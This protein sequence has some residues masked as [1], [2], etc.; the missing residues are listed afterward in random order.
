MAG[1]KDYYETLG[2]SRDASADE[3]KKAYRK[4]ARKYHP[5][6]NQDDKEAEN[7]FKEV[8]EAFEILSDPQKKQQYDQFGS[9]AFQQGGGSGFGGFG[10]GAGFN[11]EDI[12]SNF[13][14]IFG[15]IFGGGMGRGRGRSQPQSG[16]DLRYD[17]EITLEDA[18]NG[19]EVEVEIPR[20]ETC[21]TCSGSGAK[22][23]TDAKTCPKCGGTGEVKH[24]RR[25]MLGQMVQIGVC[26][27]CNG[28]GK[29]IEDPCEDCSGEGRIRN[30][31][32]IDIKVPKGIDDG[33][34]LRVAGEGDKGQ[35]G[36]PAGDLYIVV[37]VKPHDIFERHGSELY[38]KRTISMSQAAL[39]D[40]I[41]IPTISGKNAELKIPSGTQSHTVFRL[42]GQ[43]MP[44]LRRDS[45]GDMLVKAVVKTPTKLSK[46][47]K[48]ALR[49]LAEEA[50]EEVH[51]TS[52][53]FFDKMK[54][55]W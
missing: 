7:R 55:F 23:G 15:D 48:D 10:G 32:K 14:D 39:G 2:V 41:K 50:G 11:A 36:A 29:I 54:E 16:A 17:L 46:K 49:I 42:K 24:I 12:F 26:D 6:V 25:T 34:H 1:E 8:N 28:Q 5:D 4:L 35:K 40:K 9:A 45:H 52:K 44:D 33:Q 30:K 21:K 47:Q 22:P 20:F 27:K 3:I 51:E 18:Y 53:G 13:G 37:H 43:G 31:R 38:C 19:L